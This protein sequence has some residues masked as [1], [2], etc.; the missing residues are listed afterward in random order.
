M[1]A[2]FGWLVLRV[3]PEVVMWIVLALASTLP[4]LLLS[5]VSLVIA[6]G[7]RDSL[8]KL[9]RYNGDLTAEVLAFKNPWAAEQ[10]EEAKRMRD[11]HRAA[12][13]DPVPLA[14]TMARLNGDLEID[15]PLG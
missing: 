5:V 12:E 11:A 6:K 1:L 15:E 14:E 13:G 3:E 10:F 7:D 9:L 4:L 2:G 8:D